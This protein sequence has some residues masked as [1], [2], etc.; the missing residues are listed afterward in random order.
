[1]KYL[2]RYW[3]LV[4]LLILALIARDWAE[5]PAT[6]LS[7]EETVDMAQLDADYYLEKFETRKYDITGA[8]EYIVS[9]DTL[10]HYPQDDRSVIEQ[11]RL[12]LHRDGVTWKVKSQLGVLTQ[13][14]ETFTLQ[15]EVVMLRSSDNGGKEIQVRTS[16]LTVQTDANRVVTDEP[17]EMV[18][19]TWSL[20]STGLESRLDDGTL[21]LL[22]GVS[23]RYEI[24]K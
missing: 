14:P 4:P 22:S 3:V 11:P 6:T 15:G 18:A 19:A 2:Y 12:Q 21:K 5:D 8:T 13:A 16:D 17:I 20:R 7:P 23:G 1:M 24:V 9:G 10:S